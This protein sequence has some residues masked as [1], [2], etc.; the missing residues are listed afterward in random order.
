M[1]R[2][3]L[4]V[5]HNQAVKLPNGRT[6][7]I[8]IINHPGAVI[9]VPF[10]NKDTVVMLRQFR[11]A[12]KKYIYELPAGT[13]DPHESMAV[14]AR[15]ELLEETGL[16]AQKL[17]KLGFIYPVPGY[18]TEVIHIYKAEQ[19]TLTL[20]QP[21][22]YEVIETMPMTRSKIRGLMTQGKLVDAKSICAF[23]FSGWL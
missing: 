5:R 10:L 13:F 14:C 12:L 2:L 19:L 23:V 17:T 7:R 9:I 21:E 8:T 4:D 11:P 22:E 15:R 18:S 1:A 16:K 3:K 6:T 20:G